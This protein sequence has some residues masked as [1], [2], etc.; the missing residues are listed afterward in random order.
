MFLADKI[1]TFFDGATFFFMLNHNP[2][3][4]RIISSKS[5]PMP[6]PFNI[7]KERLWLIISKTWR[8]SI[9]RYIG[10]NAERY[11]KIFFKVS[12]IIFCLFLIKL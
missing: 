4:P 10:R 2:S 7:L 6:R 5:R 3:P 11:K 8:R 12:M 1:S 9:K